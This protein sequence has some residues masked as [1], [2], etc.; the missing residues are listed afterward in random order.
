MGFTIRYNCH[1]RQSLTHYHH[2]NHCISRTLI[3]A[4]IIVFS[5]EVHN[6]IAIIGFESLRQCDTFP[7]IQCYNLMTSSFYYSR[8]SS[9]K[10]TSLS[11]RWPGFDSLSGRGRTFFI[12]DALTRS[13]LCH[14]GLHRVSLLL[15]VLFTSS[16]SAWY[17]I[18]TY[19]T[20]H[21]HI[22]EGLSLFVTLC[23]KTW[24]PPPMTMHHLMEF[25]L[26]NHTAITIVIIT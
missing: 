1:L 26:D 15:V 8:W 18:S 10:D 22:R 4:I 14:R 19:N 21:T 13:D 11:Q 16:P 6:W 2:C 9:G 23:L 20:I 24:H 5:Q 12:G 17:S 25:N 3:I 7:S